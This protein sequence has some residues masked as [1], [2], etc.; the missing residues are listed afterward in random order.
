MGRKVKKFK[1]EWIRLLPSMG[2][3]NHF[4][5]CLQVTKTQVYNWIEHHGLPAQK[6]M[7][8]RW[9]VVTDDFLRWAKRT[10]RI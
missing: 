10:G 1:P 7:G 8:N 9:T 6:G 2:T 5:K 3:A 4:A